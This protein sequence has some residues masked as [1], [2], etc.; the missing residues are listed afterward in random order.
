MLRHTSQ[1]FN[2]RERRLEVYTLLGG[3]MGMMLTP[4][5]LLPAIFLRRAK[6]K[7]AS[8]G[9]GCIGSSLGGLMHWWYPMEPL[10]PRQG[11]AAK[12]L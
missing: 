9:G 2:A 6:I 10:S 12:G 3:F 11:K 7:D 4:V 8:F 5:M 1:S